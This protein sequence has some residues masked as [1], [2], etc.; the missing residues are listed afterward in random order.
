MADAPSPLGIPTMQAAESRSQWSLQFTGSG[1][2]YFRIWVV[3]TLLTLLTLGAYSAWA[4]VRKANYFARNTRLLGDCFD[5][6]ADPWAILR[7]RVVAV[8]LLGFYSFAFNFSLAAGLVAVGLL[9]ALGPLLFVSAARF[10][11]RSTRWRGLGFGLEAPGLASYAVIHLVVALWLANTVV[12]ALASEGERWFWLWMLAPV[13]GVPWMH[14]RLKA[15]QHGHI[16]FG[17]HRSRF[18][19]ALGDFYVVYVVA[20]LILCTAAIVAM[21]VVA[22]GSRMASREQGHP[23]VFEV[24]FGVGAAALIYLA[25]WPYLAARIQATVWRHTTL[26]PLRFET[27]IAFKT[28]WPLAAKNLLLLVATAGLYWPVAAVAWARYRIECMSVHSDVPIEA[29]T[30]VV[31]DANPAL[32]EGAL[33]LFGIDLGW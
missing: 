8:G 1:A 29:A 30:A 33:D 21:V 9:V 16:R 32:G 5:F 28:L 15:F 27:R 17:E 6:R 14:H 26:G 25:V 24:L 18:T 4:K 23:E 22:I 10:K 2:E 11:L 13:L 7:G 19:S 20:A 3:N 12:A 31:A